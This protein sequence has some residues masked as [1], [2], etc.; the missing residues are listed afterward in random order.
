[1]D[2]LSNIL[3]EETKRILYAE[4]QRLKKCIEDALAG[5][6]YGYDPVMY[7]RDENLPNSVDIEDFTEIKVVD[8]TISVAVYFNELAHRESGYKLYQPKSYY[9]K[10]K[11]K[12]IT[13]WHKWKGNGK[14][15]NLAYLYDKGYEVL[16]AWFAGIPN[17]GFRDGTGFIQEG[18]DNFNK[19]N[20]YNI[21]VYIEYPDTYIVD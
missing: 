12:V 3:L 2:D 11:N 7:E 10:K 17:L 9:N 19:D 13:T 5:W 15:V 1:M 4:A 18:V 14:T 8:D 6:Y 16:G 20:P 21:K